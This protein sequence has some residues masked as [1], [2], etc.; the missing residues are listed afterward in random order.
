M[1]NQWLGKFQILKY[2]SSNET[3]H[4]NF[5]LNMLNSHCT[6]SPL[7]LEVINIITEKKESEIA[8]SCPTLCNP[9]YCNLPS[10][11]VHGIFQ[12][13]VLEWI[14][15]SF[16]SGSSLP[17]SQTWVSHIVDRGFTV[18]YWAHWY[19]EEEPKVFPLVYG[20][21]LDLDLV[22]TGKML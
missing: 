12:A 2:Y 11:S 18:Y 7:L 19:W 16:S 15:I 5:I 8:Q 22:P 4:D 1:N 14:A 9:M 10:S 21:Q 6:Q 20:P 17:R 13:I 3:L